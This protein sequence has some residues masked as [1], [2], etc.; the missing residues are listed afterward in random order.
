MNNVLG[1][2]GR[3]QPKPGNFGGGG[4]SLPKGKDEETGEKVS[5]NARKLRKHAKSIEDLRKRWS[6]DNTI[7]GAL[8]DVHYKKI[9]AK[10]NRVRAIFKKQK[11][12]ESEASN[13]IVGVKFSKDRER[14]IITHYVTDSLLEDASV[15]FNKTADLI[16]SEFSGS[17]SPEELEN[18]NKRK[19]DFERYGIPKST[20][21]QLVV[22]GHYASSF[23]YPERTEIPEESIVTLYDVS[24][25]IKSILEKIGIS[26]KEHQI[27]G[28]STVQLIKP[29]IDILFKTA[30]Y[31]VAMSVIDVN[32]LAQ[33][34]KGDL[35]E[36]DTRSWMT[37]IRNPEN[38][39]IV[40]VI[41]TPFDT[42]I[43]T[44]PYFHEWVEYK[45]MIDPAIEIDIKDK[46]H[47]TAVSSII[48]DG[49]TINPELEDGCGKFRVRHFGIALNRNMSSFQIMKGIEEIIK[50]NTDIRVWNLSLGSERE[51]AD[52]HISPEAAILDTLQNK[53]NVV[54]VV[55]GTNNNLGTEPGEKLIGSPADSINSI[56]VNAVNKDGQSPDY[57]RKG[58][59]LSFF[60]KPDVSFF[61]GDNARAMKVC[62][63]MGTEY[64]TGTSLATP[65]VTRKVAFMIE[66]LGLSREVTKALLLDS[67]AD[68]N[69]TGN[70]PENSKLLGHG[71][72]PT[73]INDIV[74]TKDDEIKFY[75]EME[76][77]EYDTYTYNLPVPT[78]NAKHPFIAKATLCYFPNCNINQGVDYTSTEL[79]VY[80]GRIKKDGKNPGLKPIDKNVQSL[81]DED[82]HRVDEKTARRVFR[83]WDN[84][85]HIREVM[86]ERFVPRK[87]YD[88]GLWGI[89]IKRKNRTKTDG[90]KSIKFGLVV[91]LKEMYGANR[92]NDFI[93]RCSLHGWLVNEIDVDNSIDIYATAQETIEL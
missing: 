34:E 57:T 93:Q 9:I 75:I 85:K 70:S 4:A 14:H 61:G 68:W 79:D 6:E 27:F 83:K 49:P 58:E 19:I 71:I 76:S 42:D 23:E 21:A 62:T 17:I 74:K 64:M 63:P 28:K 53:Y 30:P 2:K 48:V 51:V 84:S 18:L 47:G 1:L 72:V 12:G 20:F 31:L 50:H 56:V 69:D 60:K 88:D 13:S 54:F 40:G 91:T 33:D 86:S 80:I 43:K 32:N 81:D 7:D 90:D 11:N 8:V 41:D 67:A 36:G 44:R 46:R 82:S 38:E 15:K 78:D 92:I 52:S 39:P 3:F 22:D 24:G 35:I 65:W 89:S 10:S 59:V 87:A 55:S 26:V 66:I 16:D 5:V 45:S 77:N 25:D 29:E 73:H 37:S